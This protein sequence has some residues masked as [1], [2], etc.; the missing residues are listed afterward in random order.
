MSKP[1]FGDDLQLYGPQADPVE[2]PSRRRARRYCRRLARRHYENF[3]VLTRLLP[4]RLRQPVAD[5][6][7]ISRNTQGVRLIRLDPNDRVVA[8]A[9]VEEKDEV[10]AESEA[11]A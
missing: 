7:S 5:I 2:P 9:K 1:L 8:V 10:P 6:R 4:R 3:S 11:P